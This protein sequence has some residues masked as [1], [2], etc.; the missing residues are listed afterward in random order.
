MAKGKIIT[1]ESTNKILSRD[2]IL[3]LTSIDYDLKI[4]TEIWNRNP[5]ECIFKRENDF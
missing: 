5:T 2:D 3:N 4:F 1:D